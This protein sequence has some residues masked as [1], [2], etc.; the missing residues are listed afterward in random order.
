MLTKPNILRLIFFIFAFAAA[1]YYPVR[2]VLA[3]ERPAVP[4][5]EMRFRARGYDPYDPMRG[6]YIN[7]NIDGS[8]KLSR[9]E[10]ERQVELFP[11]SRR[12]KAFAVLETDQEGFARVTGLLPADRRPEGKVFVK[13][14][15]FWFNK[16]YGKHAPYCNIRMPF[17]RYF[18]NEKLAQ[19]AEALLRNVTR[20]KKNAA[21]LVVD[22]YADG[23]YA[24][25]GLLIGG[26]PIREL[27]TAPPKETKK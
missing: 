2:E 5:V 10:Y 18:I 11:R 16:G 19:D 1:L 4:P 3:F 20:S 12:S 17:N 6:H 26:K 22:I 9:G 7:L 8:I 25:K 23:R 14:D 21:V 24:V 15:D 13:V 27:L